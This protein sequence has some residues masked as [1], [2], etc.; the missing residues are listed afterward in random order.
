M[1][2]S[3]PPENALLVD[4]RTP[5]E[6]AQG[7]LEGAINL[8]LSAPRPRLRTPEDLQ[9]FERSL[10]ELNGKLGLGPE[11]KVVLY[12]DG[13]TPRLARTAFFLALSGLQVFLW[14]AGWQQH[15]RTLEVPHIQAAKPWA[16]LRRELLLT[17]DEARKHLLLFDVRSPQEFT[18]ETKASCCAR[19][20]RVPGAKNAPWEMFI[21]SSGLLEQLGIVTGQEVGVYCHSGARSAVAFWVLKSLGVSVKNYLGSMHEWSGEADLPI[22]AG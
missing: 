13:L 2:T 4:T 3:K 7:H 20:G 22:E 1:I 16:R 14:P 15:E 12:D 21:N 19:S 8:D 5:A 6:Y 17:A 11:K 9:A 18:G 10:A